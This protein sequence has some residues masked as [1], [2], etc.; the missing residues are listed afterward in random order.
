MKRFLFN[1]GLKILI[2]ICLVL[3]LLFF[4]KQRIHSLF[5]F[6]QSRSEI[7]KYDKVDLA[8]FGHSQSLAGI[9]QF[10]LEDSLKKNVQN[11]SR[12]GIPLFYTVKRIKNFI[13][14][15]SEATII[16]ELGTNQVDHKGTVK[17]LLNNEN[18]TTFINF[19]KRNILYF[20]YSELLIFLKIDTQKTLVSLFKSIYTPLNVYK[21]FGV[22]RSNLELAIKN[23]YL[24]K[25]EIN[26]YWQ[27]EDKNI[28]IGINE[29]KLL[30][31]N[32]TNRD[33]III[34]LPEHNK[35]RELYSN[36]LIYDGIKNKISEIKNVKFIDFGS[37]QLE[38]NNFR[39]LNHL[40][41]EG[42][43]LTTKLLIS[44]F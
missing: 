41:N 29:L 42:M 38:A 15:N 19:L 5:Y 26:E 24:I 23:Q 31:L 18:S 32:N 30:I 39:D 44:H 40:S 8:I 11:F 43:D 21:G 28:Q 3:V 10:I 14:K 2:F 6:D 33:F 9:N 17:N 36:S 34:R 35:F 16:I 25:K 7:K 27:Y 1:I 37:L 4:S 20:N 12:Q 22:N 13:D